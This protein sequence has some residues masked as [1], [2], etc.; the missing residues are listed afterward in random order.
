VII[1]TV[2]LFSELSWPFDVAPNAHNIGL[3][4]VQTSTPRNADC[5]LPPLKTPATDYNAYF[6][7]SAADEH[8]Q[9]WHRQGNEA[10]QHHPNQLTAQ[11]YLY[12]GEHDADNYV[13]DDTVRQADFHEDEVEET[14]YL[15]VDPEGHEHF[16]NAER[17]DVDTESR[18]A[19]GYSGHNAMDQVERVHHMC[20]GPVEPELNHHVLTC[21][22]SQQLWNQQ[23][24]EL[25]QQD[26]TDVGQL[27][28][29]D[30]GRNYYHNDVQAEQQY[31]D[32]HR[33]VNII[34]Q[35]PWPVPAQF[36]PVAAQHDYLSVGAS[37]R[38]D[39]NMMSTWPRPS[40]AVS[41][42][43]EV[44]GRSPA[45]PHGKGDGDFGGY[46]VQYRQQGREQ[47]HHTVSSAGDGCKMM[48]SEQV[49]TAAAT[50]KTVPERLQQAFLQPGNDFYIC[51]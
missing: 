40:V 41:A 47:F 24:Y 9:V 21:P 38:V 26:V 8:P 10:D 1:I 13:P 6:Q 39:K 45:K 51:V 7:A 18:Y 2:Y 36:A 25:E 37:D 43:R 50:S 20:T 30:D 32:S 12:P 4:A 11:P 35:A 42:S 33:D 31:G 5:M 28:T 15:Y 14:Q 34:S 27:Q 22:Q 23:M 29:V 44:T 16:A 17:Y 3:H 48:M 46:R 49:A 19:E